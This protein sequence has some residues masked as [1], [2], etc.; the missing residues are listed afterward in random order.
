MNIME[1]IKSRIGPVSLSFLLLFTYL[2]KGDIFELRD[3]KF[4][5]NYNKYELPPSHDGKP[6]LVSTLAWN[7][8]Q[9]NQ[10]TKNSTAVPKLWVNE[11]GSYGVKY[12]LMLKDI[13]RFMCS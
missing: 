11:Y 8:L 9:K 7:L 10:N 2:V 1:E 3:I 6:L 4:D 13:S 5:S 12:M